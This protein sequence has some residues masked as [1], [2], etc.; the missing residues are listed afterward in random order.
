MVSTW[1]RGGGGG[2]GGMG[3]S[4]RAVSGGLFDD[5]KLHLMTQRARPRP[6]QGARPSLQN[7]AAP[8]KAPPPFPRTWLTRALI[9]PISAPSPVATTTPS[10]WPADTVVALKPMHLRSPSAAPSGTGVRFLEIG[11]LSPV[12]IASMTLGV[13]GLGA[14]SDGGRGWFGLGAGR[15]KLQA[16]PAAAWEP[17]TCLLP[18]TPPAPPPQP[19]RQ[20][21]RLVT[22]SRRRSAG[23]RSPLWQGGGRSAA[24]PAIWGARVDGGA[25]AP[26]LWLLRRRRS[27]RGAAAPRAAAPKTPRTLTKTM[28]PGTSSDASTDDRCPPRTTVA[29]AAVR[30]G[31]ARRGA[32]GAGGSAGPPLRGGDRKRG[33]HQRARAAC[34]AHLRSRPPTAAPPPP[35]HRWRRAWP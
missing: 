7:P 13:C 33:P 29:G 32:R 17:V 2:G 23:S 35:A 30:G 15:S 34:K 3:G 16:P 26:H 28:S 9:F 25:P 12:S 10:P 8:P 1:G 24:G 20:T 5:P 14:G 22:S 27:P 11:T 31:A 4:R 18:P 19:L 6:T 21:C